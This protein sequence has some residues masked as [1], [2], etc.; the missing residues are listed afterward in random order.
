MIFDLSS[1]NVNKWRFLTG[2]D[3]LPKYFPEKAATIKK[4]QY[5]PVGR[6]LKKQT[7]IANSNMK[8]Q[9]K[10]INLIKNKV[11]KQQIK[12]IKKPTL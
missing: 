9:S 8:D 7:D 2:K 4:F 11:T 3:V 6:E 5:S 1:G 12:I 10:F